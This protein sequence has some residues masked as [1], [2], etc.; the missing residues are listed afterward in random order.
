MKRHL[1][2]TFLSFSNVFGSESAASAT[3]D[4]GSESNNHA[5]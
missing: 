1:K 2:G 4:F 5:K 3:H